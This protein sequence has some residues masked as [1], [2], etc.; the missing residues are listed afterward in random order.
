[1]LIYIAMTGMQAQTV[2]NT[3]MA[4]GIIYNYI[5]T[6]TKRIDC[7]YH[8]LIA[9]VE[10]HCIFLAYE[11]SQLALKF[12]MICRVATHHT[13]AHWGSKAIFCGRVRICLTYFRMI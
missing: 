11:F 13:G 2:N 3:R 5:M 12:F 9:I 8:A 10:E 1:M 6:T 4:L 7:T